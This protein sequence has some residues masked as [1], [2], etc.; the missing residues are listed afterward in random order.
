M[1][2]AYNSITFMCRLL[3]SVSVK[4]LE[5]SRPVQACTGIALPFAW[6]GLY[7]ILESKNCQLWRH[8]IWCIRQ[9]APLSFTHFFMKA[10]WSVWELKR[11]GLIIWYIVKVCLDWPWIILNDIIFML[12]SKERSS[13]PY[14][15][16]KTNAARGLPKDKPATQTFFFPFLWR[17]STTRT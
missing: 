1:R 9:Y 12:C 14:L 11:S 4:L 3:K 10:W 13:R 15:Y 5:P 6:P 7:E 2:R 8:T 17:N 16:F